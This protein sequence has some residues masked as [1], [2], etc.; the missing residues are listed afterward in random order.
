MIITVLF[1]S[2]LF[3]LHLQNPAR[4]I[5]LQHISVWTW[6][7]SS[8]QRVLCGIHGFSWSLP[9]QC[10]QLTSQQTA[11]VGLGLTPTIER[12]FYEATSDF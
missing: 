9:P 8:V 7:I 4:I 2:L 5:H 1:D 10:G 6:H 12:A 3:S 11:N